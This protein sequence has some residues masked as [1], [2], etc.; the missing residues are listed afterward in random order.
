M[1]LSR[2]IAAHYIHGTASWRAIQA[3]AALALVAI[4]L[5]AWALCYACEQTQR[6]LLP[7]ELATFSLSVVLVFVGVSI[8][9]PVHA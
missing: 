2:Y 7:F 1:V 5:G 8:M 6:L 9:Q 4:L 3:S